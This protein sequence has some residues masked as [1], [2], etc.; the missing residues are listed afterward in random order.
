M[1]L[2]EHDEIVEVYKLKKPFRIGSHENEVTELR[3]R[4]LR[5]GDI[6]NLKADDIKLDDML[7][8]CER[9]TGQTKG[10]FD[11]MHASDVMGVTEIVGKQLEDSL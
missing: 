10:F 9:L 5:G 4:E 11:R 8:M 1:G 3:F 2:S 7:K 6:R